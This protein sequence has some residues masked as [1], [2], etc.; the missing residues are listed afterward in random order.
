MGTPAWNGTDESRGVSWYALRVRSNSERAVET[1]LARDGFR[2]FA[3]TYCERRRW[4]D[5]FRRVES[6]LFPGYIFSRLAAEDWAPV[7]ALAGIIHI[8]PSNVTPLP[9]ADAEVDVIRRICASALP[10]APAAFAPGDRVTVRSGPLQGAAGVIVRDQGAAHLV[11]AI[12]M[13]GRAVRVTLD[14]A[15][16]AA[17]Q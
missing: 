8:L 1:T 14:P 4:S 6:P 13:L 16:L 5:R 12:E 9:V 15:T 17:C 11:V 2:A 7:L 10:V 3:P